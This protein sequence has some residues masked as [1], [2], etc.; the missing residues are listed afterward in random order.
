VAKPSL[1]E[2]FG[3]QKPTLD[4]IFSSDTPPAPQPPVQQ[5]KT[6]GD[7]A[8]EVG[9]ALMQPAALALEGLS[10]L[11]KPR[12]A[13][14]GT[15]KAAQE[16][17]DLWEGAKKGWQENT[18]WKETFNQDWVKENPT[19][20][21]VL[22]FATDVFI[23][24][25][26]ILTPAKIARA[27]KM[28]EAAGAVKS[29]LAKT[30]QGQS[31]LS[32]A[33]NILGINNPTESAQM[34]YNAT[35]ARLT[36]D[37]KDALREVEKI[38]ANE[39][40]NANRLE[41]EG[42]A[43][44]LV[45]SYPDIGNFA[46]SGDEVAA[47]DS[48]LSTLRKEMDS[49]QAT[50]STAKER[51]GRIGPLTDDEQKIT[52]ILKDNNISVN[53]LGDA[54][55]TARNMGEVADPLRKMAK[56]VDENVRIK[57]AAY[58]LIQ[59]GKLTEADLPQL[60]GIFSES[61]LASIFPNSQK[62]KPNGVLGEV[63][64]A[65]PQ[66]PGL[67]VTPS[68]KLSLSQDGLPKVR[69]T[70]PKS[71]TVQL[72]NLSEDG[73]RLLAGIDNLPQLAE[74]IKTEQDLQ[75]QLNALER[76]KDAMQRADI[77]PEKTTEVIDSALK[78]GY[79]PKE[80]DAMFRISERMREVNQVMTSEAA[81][82]TLIPLEDA[83]AFSGG[84]HLR[85]MYA[86]LENPE[87]HYNNLVKMGY[88]E[89]ADKFWMQ[90]SRLEGELKAKGI[91][92]NT[93]TFEARKVLPKEVQDQLGKLYEATYPFA[94][95]NK[96][97]AEQFAKY[98]FLKE[99]SSK[100]G[101]DVMQPGYKKVPITEDGKLG[102]LEGKFLPEKVFQKVVFSVA[103]N[104]QEATKWEKNVQRWKAGKLLNPASIVRNFFS[105]AA[106]A[107]VFGDISPLKFPRIF[108]DTVVDM[109]NG[110]AR[111]LEARNGGLF[112]TNISKGDIE[113]I[114]NRVRG[115]T[116][117]VMDKVD[118][119]LSK[120]MEYY[121]IPD[122]FWRLFVYNHARDA[123]KTVEEAVMASKQAMFDYS[124]APAWIEKLSRTG[125]APF[126]KYPFFATK[127]TVKAVYERPTAVTKYIKPQNQVNTD[128][129]EQI[130]PDHLKAKTLLPYGE[131]TRIVN[132]K[133]QK[134]Q[135]NI[136]MSYILPF[137]NDVSLGNP[138]IEA[139]GIART[140]RNALGMDVLRPGMSG[141]EKTKAM[142]KT[143]FGSVAPTVVSPYT[144]ER[145]TNA[146]QGNV[147]SKGR[148]YSLKDA[149]LQTL[150]GIK[151]VPINTDEMYKQKVGS[152]K[153]EIT[154]TQALMRQTARD[155]SLSAEQKKE[156]LTDYAKQLKRL[157]DEVKKTNEAYQREKK[158]GAN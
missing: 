1:N 136:D 128:D 21:A 139:L 91:S 86:A 30:E 24:P 39:L 126:I 29:Q 42:I 151:N 131:S 142:L 48:V 109:K 23:D 69:V 77:S 78:M 117:G 63:S 157:G 122:N 95:G 57:K 36:G 129:R 84:R 7:I 62:L 120:G 58:K 11:D 9:S 110:T 155:Q 102:Q 50:V 97:A 94:K 60:R 154:D 2:I 92:I 90:F 113:A 114:G 3:A 124:N 112:E 100:Y 76:A 111:W 138:A 158:R 54:V 73:R 5:E 144:V 132:G 85:R 12:A 46:R 47:R 80:V 123:G 143:V 65:I 121:S 106:Q 72:A 150:L 146:V 99:I 153:R 152:I 14:A 49:A 17:T 141:E 22:G 55:N 140:G 19:A 107:N 74:K 75:K 33:E 147:D 31:L 118:N 149:A 32:K 44:R 61:E 18:S 6:I 156:R 93:G 34:A 43:Q 127:E 71:Q 37:T 20:A 116:T 137:V 108:A 130:L 88:K 101:S 133:E 134:V 59:Q 41:V 64:D 66:Q 98:D 26:A 115:N 148:Q 8:G 38:I 125:I 70:D 16:G 79:T 103:K 96:I 89:L 67:S 27:L 135:G 87:E 82:R 83:A 145:V 51:S 25:L 119:V 40:P 4:Q 81:K 104:A 105:G 68:P 45:E 52:Q 15:V 10:Y 35:K 53:Q 56:G 13:I 28:P